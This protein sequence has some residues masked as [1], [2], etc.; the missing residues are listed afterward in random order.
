MNGGQVGRVVQS[1]V[2]AMPLGDI[3]LV[4]ERCQE[5]FSFPLLK[6]LGFPKSTICSRFEYQLWNKQLDKIDVHFFQ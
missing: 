2:P 3:R 6:Y 4:G 5:D 1:V